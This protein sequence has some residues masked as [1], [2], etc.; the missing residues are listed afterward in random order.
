M[1]PAVQRYK[2]L[3]R[4]REI[5][6]V[7][8][9][10]GFYEIV[11]QVGLTSYLSLPMRAIRREGVERRV[12]APERVRMVLEELGP[13]FIK[14][15]QILSTRPDVLPPAYVREL[16]KLQDS[17]PPIPV[18]E[19]KQVI[20]EELGW[21]V[22]VF[23][24]EF[25]E[26]PLA[27]ASL[28][29]V[30]G[31]V[32]YNGRRVVVKV[33]RPHI[34]PLIERDLDILFDLAR[35]AQSRTAWGKLYDFVDIAEDFARKIRA[36]LDYR[37]EG[38]NADKFRENFADEPHLYIPEIYWEHTTSRVLTME[39]IS[40]IKIDDV[41]GIR[42][43]GMDPKRIALHSA[44]IIIREVFRDGFFHADPHPGNFFVMPGEVI[45]AMDFGMV[46]YLGNY[47]REH[48]ARLLF[49][50]VS[51]DTEGVVDELIEL[52][53]ARG[54]VDRI[55]LQ[56]D[57]GRLLGEYSSKPLK[58]IRAT[59]VV[60]EIMPIAFRYRLRLPSDLWLLGKTFG[61]M[62]GVGLKLDPDFDMFE[63]ARP[64]AREV[65]WEFLSP[66]AL[67]KKALKG[68]EDWGDLSLSLPR[69]LDSLLR[70]LDQGEFEAKL[71]IRR[72]D[73]IVKRLDKMAN[74]LAVSL[75]LTSL[76]LA[77]ALLIPQ[78]D[79]TWPWGIA[80]WLLV[81]GFGVTS[82]LGMMLVFSILR[83]GGS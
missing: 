56:R 64:Y 51:M 63:V 54:Q 20:E 35:M 83:T 26:E 2:N 29:Q 30:H 66:K 40:G 1:I 18:E 61:M 80:T 62:E 47:T 22:E 60:A 25:E 13:T 44:R 12:S 21:P 32:L 33:Q 38:L 5:V 16:S 27:A 41:E 74:R 53:A 46:G 17:A 70:Q 31:A 6:Q 10:H 7:L 52:G 57:I 50:S 81:L 59:D 82:I 76:I 23:F 58:E 3:Q 71:E 9:R 8:L 15:G 42:A 14:L 72:V 43:A 68:L 65:V 69:R 19:V 55:A 11:D 79:L 34:R 67:G 24:K 48:L 49:A 73:E 36:E 28:A 77:T 37:R 78:V 45:G 75:L 39:R 4:F